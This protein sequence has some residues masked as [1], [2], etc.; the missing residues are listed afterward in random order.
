MMGI[1]KNMFIIA[2]CIGILVCITAAKTVYDINFSNK[3]KYVYSDDVQ[4]P[5]DDALKRFSGGLQIR[6]ISNPVYSETDFSEFDRFIEYI[7]TQYPAIF[8][9]CEFSTVNKYGLVFKYPGTESSLKPNLLTAHYDVVGLKDETK[10]IH[11]PFSGF[12]D[13]NY[14]YSRG[15]IDDKGSVFAILEALNELINNG[16]KP[17]ADLYIAFSQT[18]ETG[19]SEGAPKIIEYFKNQNITFDTALDEGG[20]IV[21]KNGKYYAFV[22]VAEKGRL[23]TKITVKGEGSHASSPHRNLATQ[24]LACLIT[25]FNSNQPKAIIS[26]EVNEYY[27]QTY[28]SYGLLTKFLLSNSLVLKPFLVK[29]LSKNAEDNARIHSTTA[30]TII[31]ASNIQNA[32][33]AEASMIVDTRII[34]N[35]TTEDMKEYIEKIIKKTLPKMKENFENIK[36]EYLSKVEPCESSDITTEE[37]KQL[38]SDIR[39]LYPDIAVVP[40]LTL[41]GTDAREYA[42]ISDNTYRFLPC[43]LTQEEAALMHSDNERISVK[44]WARMISFYKEFI[45]NR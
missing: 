14:I 21:N 44:N 17:K 19:S 30:I 10:W 15:T 6:T 40:Y 24:K 34:P 37:Y 18:E 1:I 4:V 42:A 16:F 33:A 31:D 5:S 20:R 45:M 36:V 32:V 43:I 25:A 35:Q 12:Y 23:L 22:G 39:K 28:N 29:K 9:K 13:E 26:K 11:P 7:K 27:K 2:V 8:E 38:T 41:G 3:N